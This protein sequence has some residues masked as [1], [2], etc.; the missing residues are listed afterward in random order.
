VLIGPEQQ[1]AL[2]IISVM[3]FREDGKI[4]LMRAYWSGDAMR[5]S[6]PEDRAG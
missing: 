1:Q 4:T 6:T 3:Q 5:A 2:D